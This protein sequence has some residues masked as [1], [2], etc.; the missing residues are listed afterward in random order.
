MGQQRPDSRPEDQAKD[1]LAS[2][3]LRL[4]E[5]LEQIE[6]ARGGGAAVHPAWPFALGCA[7]AAFGYLGMGLPL[8][9]YP[10]LFA[11]LL[12]L[13]VYHRRF[14]RPANALWRWPLVVLNFVNLLLSLM[15]VLGGGVRHPFAWF[16]VPAVVKSAPPEN[17]SWYNSLVPDYAF[18]WH[19]IPAL[20]AWS[21]DLTRVQAFLLIAT[22]AGA[23]FRFQG[24]TSI[25]ALALLVVSIPV[26]LAFTW[27]WVVLFLIAGS[28]SLY[29]QSRASVRPFDER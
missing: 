7:A 22:L 3:I 10:Y 25:T 9:P 20:S 28:V 18:Q 21:V 2:R 12:L 14:L 1:V 17:G 4:E 23:L 29:L 19:D 8:H 16:K 24:F 13:L 27:D 6:S 15:I 5:R 26:Y 11:L